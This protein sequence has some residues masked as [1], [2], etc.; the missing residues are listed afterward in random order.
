MPLTLR[1]I[2]LAMPLPTRCLPASLVTCLF[3]RRKGVDSRLVFGV[4]SHPFEAHCWVEQGGAVVD[5][6]VDRLRAFTPIA[7]GRP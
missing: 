2:R 1:S 5:D 7:T 6:D 3:L 4:R